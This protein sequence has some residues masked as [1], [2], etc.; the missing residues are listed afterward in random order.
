MPTTL[1][2]INAGNIDEVSAKDPA[3][4]AEDRKK[5]IAKYLSLPNEVSPLY[6]KY[7]DANRIKPQG[8]HLNFAQGGSRHA[9]SGDLVK[10]LEE[11]EKETG[12][13][14]VGA[15]ISKIVIK[16]S[17]AKQ[18]VIVTGIRDAISKH[19]DIVKAHME[20]N[21]LDHGEDRFMALE[22]AAF[23]SGV[24]VY[25][26]RN[27]VLEEPI[28]IIT[29]LADDG[30]SLVSRNVFVAEQGAKATVVQELYAPGT[31]N[32]SETQQGYFELIET[33]VKQ[34]AHLE[35][36]TLQ[37]M[38]TDTVC[39]SN[40]KAFV[41]R[42]AKMSW[43]VGLFGTMLS[44]FKTDS[45]MKGQGATAE[46][47]EIVF[48]VSNQSFDIM[49][50]L[51]HNGQFSRGKVQVKSVMK[52]TS[53]SLFKGMIKIG[54]D[55]KGTESYLAGHAILLDKG[56][57]SD[58]IPGLEILTNE[59]RAT[60]SAS[61]AQIDEN[62]IFYLTTRGLS[63]EGAKREIVSGFLEPLSRKMGPTI[64]AWINYLIENKWQGNPLMLRADEA[65][66][67][68]LEVEKSRY[69]ETQDIFEKHYKYR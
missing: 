18:G 6:S 33:S 62:Q 11:L 1:A 24:F 22:A 20:A 19:A 21:P 34:N 60:H 35:A 27:V 4:L 69:R 43:Y 10:R 51:I 64:R 66:E 3:W 47:V 16:E 50:N 15:E 67:Q 56:A 57:K 65:M 8:V 54:K 63:R 28:R 17:V 29:S 37:A 23:Q 13:L 7:S 52:D 41:E 38:G 68:I 42:D 9:I 45:I 25:V 32:A 5:A 30:T 12:I 40:R 14:Q 55:G 2:N 31:G 49:S 46:D 39:V 61:V 53:K 59:V 36:V 58:S 26:P 44:R 48:G